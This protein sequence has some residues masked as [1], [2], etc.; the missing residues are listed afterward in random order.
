[1]VVPV[2]GGSTIAAIHRGFTDLVRLGAIPRA[3][4]LLGVVPAT[5][6]NLAVAWRQGIADKAAFFA[7][8]AADPPTLLTKLAHGHPPDGLEALAAIHESNGLV[9]AVDEE[10]AIDGSRRIGREDGLYVEPSSG[11]VVPAIERLL[12]DGGAGRDDTIVALLC[13]SGF[14]ETFAVMERRT[15]VVESRAIGDLAQILDS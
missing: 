7:L 3:P 10:Q 8:P 4:R 15:L 6:D 9:L 5:H 14:R 1:M 13:G 11:V 12:A 2:G